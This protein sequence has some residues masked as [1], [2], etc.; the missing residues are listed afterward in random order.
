MWVGVVQHDSQT[1]NRLGEVL[2]N[3]DTVTDIAIQCDV[4][5]FVDGSYI[6]VNEASMKHLLEVIETK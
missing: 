4:I 6:R 1:N 2:I 5:H 3:L